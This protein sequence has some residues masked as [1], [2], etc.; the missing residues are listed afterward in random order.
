MEV[1]LV[2]RD[3]RQAVPILPKPTVLPK[4]G[5]MGFYREINPK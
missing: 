4:P 1:S 3:G 2:E 5:T